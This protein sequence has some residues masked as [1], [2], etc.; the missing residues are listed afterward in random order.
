MKYENISETYE[1]NG[2]IKDTFEKSILE[3]INAY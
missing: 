2:T 1:N 3:K